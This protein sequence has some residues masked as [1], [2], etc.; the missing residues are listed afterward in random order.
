[1]YFRNQYNEA[2]EISKRAIW[3]FS[4]PGVDDMDD[5]IAD[6]YDLLARSYAYL[7]NDDESEKFFKKAIEAYE[8]LNCRY[9]GAYSDE[10]ADMYSNLG[11]FYK[12]KL[13]RFDLAK[14]I[15]EKAIHIYQ[16]KVLSDSEEDIHFRA[17]TYWHLASV[18]MSCRKYDESEEM[19]KKSVEEYL[20]LLKEYE[21]AP[22]ELKN[23]IQDAID[24][25]N[26]MLDFYRQYK[27]ELKQLTEMF[28]K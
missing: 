8:N 28:A 27:E 22:V 18:Y 9:S 15:Y 10:L 26:E 20:K 14:D 5:M 25:N 4:K 17:H 7:E 24:A 12:D 1:M 2:I 23:S 3:Y 13:E 21:D 19:I 16:E 11:D 6:Q